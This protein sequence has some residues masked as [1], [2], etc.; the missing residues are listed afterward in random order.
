MELHRKERLCLVPYALVRAVVHVF[1][2]DLPAISQRRIV[3]RIAVV[4]AC[5]ETAVCAEHPDGL[6]VA[7]VPVF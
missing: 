3:N 5:Y 1:K 6:V 7:S 4:L 2:I